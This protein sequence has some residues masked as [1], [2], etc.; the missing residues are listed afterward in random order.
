MRIRVPVRPCSMYPSSVRAP[1]F[2]AICRLYRV[3]AAPLRPRHATS[4]VPLAMASSIAA[5]SAT[6]R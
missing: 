4:T 3:I 5:E 2:A 1:G 6:V